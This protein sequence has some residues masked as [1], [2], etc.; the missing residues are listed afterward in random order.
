M[1]TKEDKGEKN[2]NIS[3]YFC[4]FQSERRRCPAISRTY[5]IQIFRFSFLLKSKYNNRQIDKQKKW[6][7]NFKQQ[8]VERKIDRQKEAISDEEMKKGRD[9]V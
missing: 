2:E 7:D 8:E 3:D 9:A 6:K 4:V 1:N 5:V